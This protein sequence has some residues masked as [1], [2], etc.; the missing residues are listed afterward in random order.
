MAQ[1]NPISDV[2]STVSHPNWQA[3]IPPF[4]PSLGDPDV[5]AYVPKT[6][7]NWSFQLRTDLVSAPGLMC[8]Q[9]DSTSPSFLVFNVYND[10]DN[11][12]CNLISSVPPT[13]PRS[14]II[15]DFNLHHPL[16][17]RDDNLD[18]QSNEADN[19]VELM[20]SN[21]YNI[22]NNRHRV[23]RRVFWVRKPYQKPL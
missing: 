1:G 2:Y 7:T 6:R 9:I 20:A 14:I 4:D 22:L 16:W 5:L 23:H 12:A 11:T 8:V 21:G 19:L 10:V 15:G 17:S 18:K 13:L 3:L